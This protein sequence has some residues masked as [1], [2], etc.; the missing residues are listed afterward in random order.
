MCPL[1]GRGARSGCHPWWQR[2]CVASRLPWALGLEAVLS[3]IEAS[4]LDSELWV[5]GVGQSSL[6]A[7]MLPGTLQPGSGFPF[8]QVPACGVQ[9][10]A[11]DADSPWWPH[12]P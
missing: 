3:A 4:L 7:L 1:G 5:L 2:G 10:W 8:P 9:A 6:L 12:T 11:G